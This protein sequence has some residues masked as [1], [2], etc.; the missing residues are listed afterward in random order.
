MALIL[1]KKFSRKIINQEVFIVPVIFTKQHL[2]VSATCQTCRD[3]WHK[4]GYMTQIINALP[5]N[6]V[7]VSNSKLI[8]LNTPKLHSF[9]FFQLG[10]QLKFQLVDWI[11]ELTIEIFETQL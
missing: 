3:S 10:Y 5:L 11:K 9:T 8:L 4:A 6:K 7:E 1:V 2:I